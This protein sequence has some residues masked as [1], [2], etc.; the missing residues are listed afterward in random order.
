VRR[1]VGAAASGLLVVFGVVEVCRGLWI[2]AKAEL[3]QVLVRRAWF[4]ARAAGDDVRPWPWADTWPVARLRIPSLGIDEVVL[5]GASGAVM[6]FAPGRLHGTAAPGGSGACVIAGHRDT[7]FAGLR[8]IELGCEV[9]LDDRSGR[10]SRYVVR[11]V[12]VIDEDELSRLECDG[13]SCLILLTCWPFDQLAGGGELRFLVRAER[14]PEVTAP[15]SSCAT[16]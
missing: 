2:P 7:H 16:S 13:P 6:A 11:E 9:R 10:A 12:A 4:A 3:A 14:E 15:A 8:S 5:D 1:R